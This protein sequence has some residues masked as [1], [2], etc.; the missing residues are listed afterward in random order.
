MYYAN[1]PKS[2]DDPIRFQCDQDSSVC[3]VFS[4]VF[5]R[6]ALSFTTVKAKKPVKRKTSTE[7]RNRTMTKKISFQ[8][9]RVFRSCLGK[10]YCFFFFFDF[11][12]TVFNHCTGFENHS[13]DLYNGPA[14]WGEIRDFFFLTDLNDTVFNERQKI[15]V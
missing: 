11:C 15:G 6:T 2:T 9:N 14:A 7:Y 5:R 1:P 13:V 12:G 3:I 10:M 4:R 8:S